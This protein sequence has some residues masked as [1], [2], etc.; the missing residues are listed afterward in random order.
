VKN[1]SALITLLLTTTLLFSKDNSEMFGYDKGHV[2]DE[3]QMLGAYND[4]ARIDVRGSFDTFITASFIYWQPREEG[5]SLCL[6]VKDEETDVIKQNF[7]YHPGFK[8]GLGFNTTFDNWTIY[9][10]YIRLYTNDLTKKYL[11]NSTDLL[12]PFW[13]EIF[14]SKAKSIWDLKTNILDLEIKRSYYIGKKLFLSPF[15]GARGAL[16]DQ[17]YNADYEF[18]ELTEINFSKNESDSWALGPRAGLSAHYLLCKGF[19]F[20]GNVAASIL[21]QHFKVKHEKTLIVELIPSEETSFA[22]N[23]ISYLS[24]NLEMG[25]WLSYGSYFS[26]KRFYAKLDVGYEALIFWNQ[27][28]LRAL[29]DIIENRHNGSIGN[30]ILHGLTITGRFDF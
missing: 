4:P 25:L 10:Q 8:V 16:I 28:T 29:N 3:N 11:K 26:K 9:L 21:Y 12:L 2:V 19:K 24:P 27:N 14:A 30:L 20:L 18:P 7:D 22:K 23:K 17:K 15:F 1:F 13:G 5:L 6:F